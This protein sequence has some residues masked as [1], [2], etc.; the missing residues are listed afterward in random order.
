VRTRLASFACSWLL[1]SA[2]LAADPLPGVLAVAGYSGADRTER[3]IAGAKKE[4]DLI[5]Y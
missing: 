1:A 4:G 5:I 3:L 2:A